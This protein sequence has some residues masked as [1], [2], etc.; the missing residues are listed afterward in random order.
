MPGRTFT[1]EFKLTVVRQLASGEKRPAQVCCEHGLADSVLDRWRREYRE[2][3]DAAFSPKTGTNAASPLE[4]RIA[5]LER[6]CG[7]LAL[8]NAVLKKALQTLQS[9][10]PGMAGGNVLSRSDT[11]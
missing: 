1:R 10:H 7:Q 9:G 3:G 6:F 5:E 11:P 8:E 2:R 4:A